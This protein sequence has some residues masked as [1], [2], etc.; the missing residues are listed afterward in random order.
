[1]HAPGEYLHPMGQNIVLLTAT[2]TP[3]SAQP[4]LR[5]QDPAQRLQDYRD[6][7]A[8]YAAQL[9]A[10][11]IDA[12]VFAEN[13]GHSLAP[14]RE[15]YTDPRIEWLV[16]DD[17]DYPSHYHRGYGEFR[18]IDRAMAQ[19]RIIAAAGDDAVIWKITGRYVIENL[20]SVIRYAPRRFALYCKL[21]EKWVE[22][23][24][25][26]WTKRGHARLLKDSADAFGTPM[27]PELILAPRLMATQLPD[28]PIVGRFTWPPLIVG[29]RGTDGTPFTSWRTRLKFNALLLP[30]LAR[31]A[32]R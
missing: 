1:V 23:S 29:R 9:A 3:R 22:M 7:F 31:I 10:G 25:M 32:F 4:G 6:A 13:S 16:C 26:A 21:D 15:A 28:C 27:A 12:I 14:L 24:I 20:R 2:I 8:F 5:L 17:L 18:L 11:T 30:R 19:S